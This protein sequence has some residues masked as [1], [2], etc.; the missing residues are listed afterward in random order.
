M[1]WPSRHRLLSEAEREYVTRAGASTAIWRGDDFSPL[2]ANSAYPTGGGVRA[3]P[4]GLR[5]TA[6]LIVDPLGRTINAWEET[7]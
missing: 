6:V 3:A 7:C 2:Q 5:L 4:R 1:G